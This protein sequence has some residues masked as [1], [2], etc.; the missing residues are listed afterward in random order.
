[1]QFMPITTPLQDCRFAAIDFESAGAATGHTDVPIQIGIAEWSPDGGFGKSFVSY[2]RGTEGITWRAQKV[3]GITLQDLQDAPELLTLWPVVKEHL[4]NRVIV[5]HGKGT[6]KKFLRAFPGHGFGPWVD[7]L[8]L[9]R[10]TWPQWQDHSLGVLCD[11][12]ELTSLVQAACPGRRW[13]DALFDAIASLFLLEKILQLTQA[14]H[15]PLDHVTQPDQSAWHR[16]QST[17]RRS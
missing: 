16:Y 4:G 10:A 15:V 8:L 7:T 14:W 2:L 13:H 12:L 6:E 9:S 17:Q 1:M 3:H 5:A 11:S